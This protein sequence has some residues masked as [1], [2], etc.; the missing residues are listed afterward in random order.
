MPLKIPTTSQTLPRPK[1]LQYPVK[2]ALAGWINA[3]A[4]SCDGP[5]DK[6]APALLAKCSVEMGVTPAEPDTSKLY[7]RSS[8]RRG[9]RF[10]GGAT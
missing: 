8:C 10:Y 7:P 9:T 2:V 5:S 6:V 4:C 1:P 3:Q